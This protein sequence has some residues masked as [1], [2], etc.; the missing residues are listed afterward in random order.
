MTL[1]VTI[2]KNYKFSPSTTFDQ[3]C[4]RFW[5]CW[6]DGQGEVGSQVGS[7]GR[8]NNERKNHPGTG[9]HPRRGAFV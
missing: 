1:T 2:A 8:G 3:L 6:I 5:F 9:Q 4:E 7:V